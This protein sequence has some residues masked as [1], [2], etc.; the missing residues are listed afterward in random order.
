MKR[1]SQPRHTHKKAKLVVKPDSACSPLAQESFA[2]EYTIIDTAITAG[3]LAGIS[4]YVMDH[5]LIPSFLNISA[6]NRNISQSTKEK[7]VDDP[8]YLWHSIIDAVYELTTSVEIPEE[9]IDCEEIHSLMSELNV[10]SEVTNETEFEKQLKRAQ[11][12]ISHA[13]DM[14][15]TEFENNDKIYNSYAIEKSLLLASLKSA[16]LQKQLE[17]PMYFIAHKHIP[18][19]FDIYSDLMKRS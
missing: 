18:Q 19:I 2:Y 9:E 17:L 6:N 5:V 10:E 7:W 13:I 3:L 16:I 12:V 15:A 8:H 11:A 14:S 1:K 4:P